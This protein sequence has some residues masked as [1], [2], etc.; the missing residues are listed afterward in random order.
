MVVD[1]GQENGHPF[2]FIRVTASNNFSTS[3]AC[4][5]L[6]FFGKLAVSYSAY[7]LDM[8]QHCFLNIL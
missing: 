1:T 5:R 2:A 7:D 3:A 8:T 6:T 4:F